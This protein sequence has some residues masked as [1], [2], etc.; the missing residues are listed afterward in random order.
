MYT[1]SSILTCTHGLADVEQAGKSEIGD[2]RRTPFSCG[3]VKVFLVAHP[4]ASLLP[5]VS[6]EL[7]QLHIGL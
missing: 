7:I 2:M 4:A 1:L 3:M 5:G 6:L